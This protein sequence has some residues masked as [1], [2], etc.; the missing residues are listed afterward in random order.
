ML[1]RIEVLLLRH[2]LTILRL[3]TLR[4]VHLL[5][6]RHSWLLLL[7]LLA[8]LVEHLLR[9][10]HLRLLLLLV[11][12]LLFGHLLRHPRLRLPK[13]LLSIRIILLEVLLRVRIMLQVWRKRPLG[14]LLRKSLV[15]I[16]D[17]CEVVAIG[18][19]GLG[20]VC[21]GEGWLGFGKS[22]GFC[23]RALAT[24]T[25]AVVSTVNGKECITRR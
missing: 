2:R 1:I 10:V 23:R 22:A 3:L 7:L 16:H 6:R 15:R 4:H 24:S 25:S 11:M 9:H 8:S 18:E 5:W 17:S 21:T 12:E 20:D 14:A 19:L 13:L